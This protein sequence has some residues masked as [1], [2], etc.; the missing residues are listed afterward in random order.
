MAI[1]YE[2]IHETRVIPLGRP[3]PHVG[4][5]IRTYMGDARGHWDGNTLVVETTNFKDQT[6]YRGADGDDAAS[7]RTLQ[8]DRAAYRRVVGHRGRSGDVDEAVDVRDE[9]DEE[10]RP[11]SGP[12]NTRATRA[13]TACETFS[14]EPVLTTRKSTRH[15]ARVYRSRGPQILLRPRESVELMMIPTHAA[16]DD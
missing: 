14:A 6:A 8:A 7:G 13:T 5:G 16:T 15:G 3:R 11:A 12:S 10:G 4:K 9:P 2:M 1:I